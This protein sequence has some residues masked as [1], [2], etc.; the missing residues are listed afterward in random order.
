MALPL[1]F[2]LY[3]KICTEFSYESKRHATTQHLPVVQAGNLIVF[4]QS[5]LRLNHRWSA[6]VRCGCRRAGARRAT[7]SV[8]SANRGPPANLGMKTTRHTLL[9]GSDGARASLAAHQ[10]L[11]EP[12]WAWDRAPLGSLSTSI[13]ASPTPGSLASVVDI[14]S[15]SVA[16]Q[17]KLC[18]TCSERLVI[19][20]IDQRGA[21]L[22][23]GMEGWIGRP[24]YT[25]HPRI[26]YI[27]W[28]CFTSNYDTPWH[29]STS[30]IQGLSSV[31]IVKFNTRS[32][33]TTNEIKGFMH[34][35]L[36]ISYSLL[37]SS[38]PDSLDELGHRPVWPRKRKQVAIESVDAPVRVQVR[39][40]SLRHKRQK[41]TD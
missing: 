14:E 16:R 1:K 35:Y 40:L 2:I 6:K 7:G 26:C 23:N 9:P 3:C 30:F 11:Q 25:I 27:N 15:L 17:S 36:V 37:E 31:F 22:I 13:S 41:R 32:S 10:R 38:D 28:W 20:T 21:L 34:T 33:C 4:A 19:G 5:E 12:L 29:V 8:A 39:A 18:K 24:T